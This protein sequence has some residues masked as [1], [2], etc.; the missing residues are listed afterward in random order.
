M[1]N[2]FIIFKQTLAIWLIPIFILSLLLEKIN[3]N[4]TFLCSIIILYGIT[5]LICILQNNKILF[6]F[7][8]FLLSILAINSFSNII[9]K[10]KYF[11]Y[12]ILF[13]LLIIFVYISIF[14]IYKNLNKKFIL[15]FSLLSGS[16]EI[17]F[18]ISLIFFGIK[19]FITIQIL[20]VAMFDIFYKIIILVISIYFKKKFNIQW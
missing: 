2:C 11:I 4:N 5:I 20:F 8:R 13:S 17:L 12:S 15:N 3:T 10:Q 19:S 18:F 16:I 6:Y 1:M 7:D 9:L 14:Y